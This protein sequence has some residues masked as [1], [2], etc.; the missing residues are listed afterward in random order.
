MLFRYADAKRMNRRP[1]LRWFR[2]SEQLEPVANVYLSALPTRPLHIEYRFLAFVQALEGYHRRKAAGRMHLRSRLD[3]LVADLPAVLRTHVPDDFTMLAKN[4][5]D[6][7]SHWEP[8][9]EAKA[10]KGERLTALT[11]AVKLLFELAMLRE[12]G[13]GRTEI[14]ELVD[15]NVRLSSD[16]RRGFIALKTM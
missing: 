5:R 13:F 2:R 1:I 15:R 4:T 12:L 8:T 3:A 7:F 11:V 9:L 10:A 14:A 16:L 6:Y